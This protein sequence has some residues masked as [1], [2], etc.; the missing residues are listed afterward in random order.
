MATHKSARGLTCVWLGPEFNLGGAGSG[1]GLNLTRRWPE[2]EL[3]PD[4]I[5]SESAMDLPAISTGPDFG[6]KRIWIQSVLALKGTW[7][8]SDLAL[9]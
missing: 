7:R 4:W 8:E 3:G 1:A 9:A 2:S 6:L 5:Y